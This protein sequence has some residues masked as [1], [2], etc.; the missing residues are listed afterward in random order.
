MNG[1]QAFLLLSIAA[2]CF[3]PMLLRLSSPASKADQDTIALFLKNRDQTLLSLRKTWIGGPAKWGGRSVYTQYGRPYRLFV[4]GPD[5]SRWVHKVVVL[6]EIDGLGA[7][8]MM[9]RL[10]D[11]WVPVSQ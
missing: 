3:G 9:Q 1:G 7:H 4:R 2:L 10:H 5:G 6:D 11:S 8:K